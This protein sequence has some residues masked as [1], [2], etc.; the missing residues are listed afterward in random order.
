MTLIN[1]MNLDIHIS[2]FVILKYVIFDF[3]FV[4]Y[5]IDGVCISDERKLSF[6][7]RVR[8]LVWKTCRWPSCCSWRRSSSPRRRRR[9]TSWLRPPR[10]NSRRVAQRERLK[11]RPFVQWSEKGSGRVGL[12]TWREREIRMSDDQSQLYCCCCTFARR[13]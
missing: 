4:F 5:G 6:A 3:R 9:C 10:R 2:R 1:T 12:G 13:L 7:H 11:R 8:L